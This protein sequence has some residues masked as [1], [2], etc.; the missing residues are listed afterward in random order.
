VRQAASAQLL[1]TA[2]DVS[3]GGLAIALSEA[4]LLN[5]IGVTASLEGDPFTLLFAETT[6][7]A[8]IACRD[9]AAEQVLALAGQHH[10]P[11]ALLGRTG[12]DLLT[13]EGMFELSLGD[14]RTAHEGT[15][16]RLFG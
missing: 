4:A 13:V 15:L 14:L 8:V 10:V 2:H 3:D 5:D 12:G 1:T 7:R 9:G 6:A 16:P 11:V